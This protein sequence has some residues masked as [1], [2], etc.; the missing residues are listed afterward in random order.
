VAR[1][2]LL[3]KC[4]DVRITHPGIVWD[5]GGMYT[6]RIECTVSLNAFSLIGIGSTT[7]TG[8]SVAPL[9]EFRRVS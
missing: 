6:I 9:D 8:Q 5:H 3:G 2:Q 4:T 1:D 7:V